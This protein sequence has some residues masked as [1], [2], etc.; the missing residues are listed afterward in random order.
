M[1][2]PSFP[3]GQGDRK[4]G[5]GE[6]ISVQGRRDGIIFDASL[7]NPLSVEDKDTEYPGG[8]LEHPKIVL[9]SHPVILE[10]RKREGSGQLK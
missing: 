6:E 3:A 4:E 2:R 5:G 8:M 9:E 1:T 7:E 10:K